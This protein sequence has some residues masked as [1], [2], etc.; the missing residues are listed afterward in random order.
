MT[1]PFVFNVAHS[2]LHQQEYDFQSDSEFEHLSDEH[3]KNIGD[4]VHFWYGRLLLTKHLAQTIAAHAP[5]QT[6]TG[7]LDVSYCND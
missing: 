4:E 6:P 3:H 2:A 7:S 1:S 5:S